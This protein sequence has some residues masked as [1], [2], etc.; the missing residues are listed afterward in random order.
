MFFLPYLLIGDGNG[1]VRFVEIAT[2]TVNVTGALSANLN[3]NLTNCCNTSEPTSEQIVSPNKLN[4][5]PA[6]TLLQSYNRTSNNGNCII[7]DYSNKDIDT[8]NG[9]VSQVHEPDEM[10]GMNVSSVTESQTADISLTDDVLKHSTNA[11]VITMDTNEEVTAKTPTETD[12]TAD[13]TDIPKTRGSIDG[14]N[15]P[16]N[17]LRV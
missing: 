5:E 7:D 2:Q 10:S 6:E 16:A 11:S 12:S 8:G 17:D 13:D 4:D 1:C 15:G 9:H 14:T 3:S